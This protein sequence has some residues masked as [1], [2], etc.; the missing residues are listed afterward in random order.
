MSDPM[1]Q[2][3]VGDIGGKYSNKGPG[4]ILQKAYTR[5]QRFI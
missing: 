1:Y 4:E 2:V 3:A 5:A